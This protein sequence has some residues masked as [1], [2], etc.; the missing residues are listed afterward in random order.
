MVKISLRFTGDP[1]KKLSKQ[2]NKNINLFPG[3]LETWMRAV[4]I[5]AM[6]DG[7]LG[8]Q[9]IAQTEFYHYITSDAGLSEL[10]IKRDDPPKLL[11]AYRTKAFSVIKKGKTISLRFGNVSDLKLQTPHP[12]AGV[13]HLKVTS[14]LEF[15]TDKVK[16]KSGFVPRN[17]IPKQTQ[18]AIRLSDPLGGLMLPGG[19]LGSSGGWQVPSKFFNYDKLWFQSN[20]GKINQAILNQANIILRD[21]LK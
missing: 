1:V 8:I 21:V 19:I 18:R 20:I 7:G 15:F 5:P 3:K 6:V 17:K 16:I 9:G 4:L 12:Y 10:G 14:W 2:L 11:N 13:G